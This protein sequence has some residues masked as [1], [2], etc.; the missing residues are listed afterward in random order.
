MIMVI[1][2]LNV[3]SLYEDDDDDEFS[4]SLNNN[5]KRKWK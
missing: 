4:L 3:M 5:D 1:T 2:F